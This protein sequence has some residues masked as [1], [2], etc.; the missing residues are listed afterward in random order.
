[1]VEGQPER[2]ATV[3]DAFEYA[4][5]VLSG[6]VVAGHLV[7]LAC[8]RM[9][10]DLEA[11]EFK[12]DARQAQLALDFFSFCRHV[13]GA[14]AGLPVYLEPWQAFIVVNIFGWLRPDGTRRFRKAYIEVARK[15]GKS[16]LLAVIGLMLLFADGEPGA[17][18]YSA[19][20]SKDQARIIWEAAALMRG[21]SPDLKRHI[22]I[23][24]SVHN[25]HHLPTG[26]K[27]EPRSSDFQRLD[28]LNPHGV[29]VDEMHAHRDRGVLDV[30]DE[31]TGARRQ[32]LTFIITTAGQ[33]RASA[34]WQER[35]YAVGVLDGKSFEDDT[36][37]AFIA[38]IDREY[39]GAAKDDD[40]TDPNVWP[41][42]NPNL[43]VSVSREFLEERV[44]EA[45]SKPA[46][47][48]GVRRKHFNE[49][50][51]I[52]N[53]WLDM[54]KWDACARPGLELEA[55]EGRACKLGIDL[56]SH[57]DITA[58]VAFFPPTDELP[59]AMLAW[60]FVPEGAIERRTREDRVPYRAWA[61]DGHLILTSGDVLDAGFV[62]AKILELTADGL[63]VDEVAY[64][65]HHAL[66]MAIELGETHG[67][68]VVEVRQGYAQLNEPM[69]QLEGLVLSSNLIHEGHPVM[70]WMVGNVVVDESPDGKIRPSKKKSREKIDGPVA[71]VT[72][73]SRWINSRPE[74]KFS[75]YEKKDLVFL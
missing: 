2:Q 17:E 14:K 6:A 32:P 25:M 12:F 69:R 8:R 24:P 10:D 49:W 67:M 44:N 16:L 1:M 36:L 9:L 13:K 61:E 26:S 21:A 59:A 34:C 71:G 55:F 30:L 29:L 51:E 66:Q 20:T 54:A 3:R 43:G 31:A 58:L 40:W 65:P 72:A 75:P 50:V 48:P 38:C 60:L 47:R 28:G 23:R 64:D 18:V 63:I 62:V 19:A 41:K 15:N 4:E 22:G 7:K 74:E 53:R 5:G 68:E 70:R 39:D 52:S 42:A 37:F 56:A 57:V 46:M 45:K 27:F 73:M 35:E 11:G 33:S